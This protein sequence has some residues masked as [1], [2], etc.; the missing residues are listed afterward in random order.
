MYSLMRI[1]NEKNQGSKYIQSNEQQIFEKLSK[2]KTNK[3]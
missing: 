2:M 1:R 3:T